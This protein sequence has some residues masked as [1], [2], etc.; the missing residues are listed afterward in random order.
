MNGVKMPKREH[1]TKQLK[2]ENKKLKAENAE[3]KA[4]NTV[5]KQ[6][7]QEAPATP[8]EYMTLKDTGKDVEPIQRVDR[9]DD[10]SVHEKVFVTRRGKDS[11]W[12]IPHE[13][14]AVEGSDRAYQIHEHQGD[15]VDI[16]VMD[17]NDRRNIVLSGGAELQGGWTAMKQDIKELW[18]DDVL[19]GVPI[20][21]IFDRHGFFDQFP[22]VEAQEIIR[23][24][25]YLVGSDQVIAP[26]EP[27]SPVEGYWQ[28]GFPDLDQ[29][30]VSGEG[31]TE[32]FS[33]TDVREKT[34]IWR[35][36]RGAV[37]VRYVNGRGHDNPVHHFQLVGDEGKPDWDLAVSIVADPDQDV[38]VSFGDNTPHSRW[39][40]RYMAHEGDGIYGSRSSITGKVRFE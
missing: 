31:F 4:E 6:S 24:K 5:L 9:D 36:I 34:R 10:R 12:V 33:T 18:L 1:W 29:V 38:I 28:I 7:A 26:P 37:R 13:Y 22:E 16:F 40:G 30:V 35:A 23:E 15:E 3:L 21:T 17:D 39:V 11:N 20:R 2:R 32:Y 19:R 14:F 8:A 27:P 25:L